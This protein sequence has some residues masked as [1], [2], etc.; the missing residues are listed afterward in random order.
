MIIFLKCSVEINFIVVSENTINIKPIKKLQFLTLNNLNF[1]L[2]IKSIKKELEL[3]KEYKLELKIFY[4]ILYKCYLN[5]LLNNFLFLY[6]L[7]F[8]LFPKLSNIEKVEMKKVL[9][10]SY[11]LLCYF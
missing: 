4:T 5:F 11:K 9:G 1:P 8:F 10:F 7:F 3:V 6:P 2:M